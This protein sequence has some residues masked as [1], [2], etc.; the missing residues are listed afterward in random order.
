MYPGVV[1]VS[2]IWAAW[3]CYKGLA[4]RYRPFKFLTIGAAAQQ[5]YE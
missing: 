5:K 3:G 4:D 2:G 1:R